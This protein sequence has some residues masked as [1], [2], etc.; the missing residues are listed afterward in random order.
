M[1]R[2]RFNPFKS[3]AKQQKQ[4]QQPLPVNLSKHVRIIK[5]FVKVK[6]I[7]FST[8]RVFRTMKIS[9]LDDTLSSSLIKLIYGNSAISTRLQNEL[10]R[11]A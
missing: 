7:K 1:L 3:I 6:K 10:K 8:E 11:V 4:Q 2:C 9:S 5:R